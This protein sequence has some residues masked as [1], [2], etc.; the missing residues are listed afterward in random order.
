[1]P[2]AGVLSLYGGAPSSANSA[3]SYSTNLAGTESPI[4]E[5]SIWT[6]GLADGGDWNNVKTIGGRAVGASQCGLGDKIYD[7]NIAHIK[8]SFMAVPANQFA[9]GT[10]GLTGGY[11]PANYHEIEL[12]LRFDIT[13]HVARGIEIMYGMQGNTKAPY[14]SI[15]V[16]NGALG[17][18]VVIYDSGLGGIAA[19]ADG[20]VLRAEMIGSAL[21]VYRNGSQVASVSNSRWPTGQPGMGFY[22][23]SGAVPEN[24]GWKAFSAGAL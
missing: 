19:P 14:L 24:Y 20:V 12:L 1:M 5:S 6:N 2:P 18:F 8:S 10:I 7:D 3:S 21:K 15:A 4:S 22:P 13:S 17:D 23:L 9:Q 16:W 11:T